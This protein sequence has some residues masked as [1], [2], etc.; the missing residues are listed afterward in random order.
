MLEFWPPTTFFSSRTACCLSGL[1]RAIIV[2]VENP[3]NSFLWDVLRAFE[4]ALQAKQV[5]PRLAEVWL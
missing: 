4:P 1:E 2:C 3:A 5:L